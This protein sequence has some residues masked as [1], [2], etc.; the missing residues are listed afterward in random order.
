MFVV[1]QVGS[2]QYMAREKDEI[3]VDY[4][5][6]E[7]GKNFM[8]DKV[9]LVG[10]EDGKNVKIGTPYLDNVKVEARTIAMEKGEKIRIF[11]MKPKKR[12]ERTRGHRSVF[13]RVKIL[14][15]SVLSGAAKKPAVVAEKATPKKAAPKP[16]KPAAPKKPAAKK[17]TAKA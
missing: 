14:K 3:L 2:T 4:M 15:V 7:D 12:Y 13:T 17:E 11:K 10:E 9:L 8:I 6:L 1:I 16:P 5:D